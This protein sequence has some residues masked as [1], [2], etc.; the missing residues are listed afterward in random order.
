MKCFEKKIENEAKNQQ[1]SSNFTETRTL[2][3]LDQ[4]TSKRAIRLRLS[5]DILSLFT[6]QQLKP[7]Q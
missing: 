6:I 7:Y 4:K 5:P 3:L 2:V 1:K